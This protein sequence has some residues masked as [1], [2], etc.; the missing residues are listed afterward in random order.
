MKHRNDMQIIDIFSR[1]VS[2][3]STLTHMIGLPLQGVVLVGGL[4]QLCGA[5][6]S[7]FKIVNL[8][9]LGYASS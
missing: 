7:L 4:A 5:G 3:T 8:G 9:R 2:I 6:T 1:W